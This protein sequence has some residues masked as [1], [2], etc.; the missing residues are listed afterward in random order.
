MS[1]DLIRSKKNIL[2]VG[3]TSTG[4]TTFVNACIAEMVA[5]CPGDRIIGV[6][7]TRELICTAP[8]SVMM[9][10]TIDIS[11]ND[12]LKSVLRMTPDR[13]LCGEVRSK[14]AKALL[15]MWS[16]G[17]PGGA[18]TVHGE[19]AQEGLGRVHRL[20]LEALSGGGGNELIPYVVAQ[21]INLVVFIKKVDDSPA[22]RRVTE[23]LRVD[24]FDPKTHQYLTSQVKG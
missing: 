10:S 23:V 1:S 9:R 15:E 13:I 7:D 3:G 21:A 5:S 17:H 14:E 8:N 18:S 2:V 12:L 19:S 20:A 11:M 4:K 6:E 24:G 22:K 16:T